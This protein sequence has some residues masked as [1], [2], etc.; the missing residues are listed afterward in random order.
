MNVNPF[1][2]GQG[3][4]QHS[5]QTPNHFQHGKN[6]G[7]FSQQQLQE[8]GQQ[9]YAQQPRD[10]QQ[11]HFS[12]TNHIGGGSGGNISYQQQQQQSRTAAPVMVSAGDLKLVD[13]GLV[14][15]ATKKLQDIEWADESATDVTVV[16]ATT[17][18]F[19]VATSAPVSNVFSTVAAVAAVLRPKDVFLTNFDENYAPAASPFQLMLKVGNGQLSLTAGCIPSTEP[20]L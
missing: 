10:M 8:H 2:Q 17:E 14:L 3:I 18:A 13:A 7:S 19:S 12:S 6:M 16:V 15:N 20:Q 4:Q 1:A 5:Y 11:M 9:Q